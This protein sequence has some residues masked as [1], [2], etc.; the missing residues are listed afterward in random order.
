MSIINGRVKQPMI[1]CTMENYRGVIKKCGRS[2]SARKEPQDILQSKNKEPN[3]IRLNITVQN[4]LWTKK[5]T[6]FISTDTYV[7]WKRVCMEEKGLQH[8]KI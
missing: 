6:L 5:K 3:T 2:E 4:N 7:Y 8:T 1:I